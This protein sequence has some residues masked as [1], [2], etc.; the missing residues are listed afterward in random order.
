MF[1]GESQAWDR[2]DGEAC[3]SRRLR[4]G[5]SWPGPGAGPRGMDLWC[6]YARSGRRVRAGAGRTGRVAGGGGV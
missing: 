4:R 2:I 6:R 1:F 5:G 3:W